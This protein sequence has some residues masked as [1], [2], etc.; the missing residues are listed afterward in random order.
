[1]REAT[2]GRG[3][4]RLRRLLSYRRRPP[5]AG[6]EGFGARPLPP[7]RRRRLRERLPILRCRRQIRIPPSPLGTPV[8]L[9]TVA[10]T[11]RA[12][13]GTTITA[14]TATEEAAAAVATAAA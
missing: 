3:G 5:L 8:L 1:M 2:S 11:R 7:L 9:S 12:C 14:C 13:A 6:S 10:H 4:H